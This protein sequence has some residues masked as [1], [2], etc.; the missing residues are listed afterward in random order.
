[1][2]YYVLSA[3]RLDTSG[4]RVTHVLWE[5][6][7]SPHPMHYHPTEASVLDVVNALNCG[8]RVHLIKV[9]VSDEHNLGPGFHVVI[10]PGGVEGIALDGF[11]L[12]DLPTF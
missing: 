5:R 1:M 4:Q 12:N 10:Y 3:V 7:N 8:D 6:L 11:A 2:S 9:E